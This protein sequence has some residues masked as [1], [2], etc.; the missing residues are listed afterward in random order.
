MG[1]VLVLQDV[2]APDGGADPVAASLVDVETPPLTVPVQSVRATAPLMGSY[3]DRVFT[4]QPRPRGGRGGVT[5]TPIA[6]G[7]GLDLAYATCP[8]EALDP[9]VIHARQVC[10][11]EPRI[12]GVFAGHG[13]PCDNPA[14]GDVGY[15]GLGI[16]DVGPGQ[17]ALALGL[18]YPDTGRVFAGRYDRFT[19]CGSR[20]GLRRRQQGHWA[21]ELHPG[22]R[23]PEPHPRPAPGAAG[24]GTPRGRVPAGEQDLHLALRGHPQAGQRRRPLPA[25]DPHRAHPRLERVGVGDQPGPRHPGPRGRRRATS[26]KGHPRPRPGPRGPQ[27][28]SRRRSSAPM[29]RRAPSASWTRRPPTT[30]PCASTCPPVAVPPVAYRLQVWAAAAGIPFAAAMPA[31]VT[32]PIAP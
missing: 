30:P 13:G 29:E 20:P 22:G 18:G 11:Y 21:G 7:G 4:G 1:T 17:S 19:G 3:R 15:L 14:S 6:G 5:G 8:G 25:A 32:D 26:A 23:R 27:P 9:V 16:R 31:C 12:S 2:A 28:T 10:D 24:P